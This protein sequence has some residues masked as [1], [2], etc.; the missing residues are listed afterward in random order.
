MFQRVFLQHLR[1]TREVAGFQVDRGKAL[2][3]LGIFRRQT[4]VL[5]VIERGVFKVLLEFLI[6]SSHQQVGRGVPGIYCHHLFQVEPGVVFFQFV[7]D[8]GDIVS[9]FD[10]VPL[11]LKGF[12]EVANGVVGTPGP[13]SEGKTQSVIGLSERVVG[14]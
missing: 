2:P 13:P 7:P 8:L 10:I 6:P 12:L 1:D 14:F 4:D 9:G 3:A 11:V 5:G